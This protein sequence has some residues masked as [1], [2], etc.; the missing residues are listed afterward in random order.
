MSSAV[1]MIS[2]LMVNKL[3]N[4]IIVMNDKM[5]M[6]KKKYSWHIRIFCEVASMSEVGE[7]CAQ[8]WLTA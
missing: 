1:V 7:E 3:S 2:S 8:Y 4:Q 5:T 6:S